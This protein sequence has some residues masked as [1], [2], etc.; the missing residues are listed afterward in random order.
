MNIGKQ[1]PPP[2][3]RESRGARRATQLA[4]ALSMVLLAGII[5]G[6][7]TSGATNAN[8]GEDTPVMSQVRTEPTAAQVRGITTLLDAYDAAWAAYDATAFAANYM[9]DGEII[10][11]IAG[12]LAGR[13]AIRAAHAF[14]FTGPFAGSTSSTAVR[15]MVF[16]TGTTAMVDL[17]V[18]LTGYQ[19]LP[20][21]LPESEP[22]VVRTRVKW[23]VVRQ[24]EG[25]LILAQQ[26]TPLPAGVLF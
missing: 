24:G 8:L 1:L 13:E 21:G 17:N 11:P 4:S 3:Q 5:A 7:D 14:L 15:R 26:M 20:P 22:G 12:I 25:W 9:E 18:T 6:C 10:N 2:Y 23:I 16:L 19:A